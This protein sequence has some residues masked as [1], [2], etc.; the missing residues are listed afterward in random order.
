MAARITN[1]NSKPE[2]RS[3]IQTGML[4]SRLHDNVLGKIEMSQGQIKSAE[5]LLRKSLPDLSA[6]A[7]GQDETKGPVQHTVTIEIVEK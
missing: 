1:P 6:V 3:K 7:I 2:V 5:I 4:L